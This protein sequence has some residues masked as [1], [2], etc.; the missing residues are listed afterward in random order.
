[1]LTSEKNNVYWIYRVCTST[2][3]MK[4]QYSYNG[5]FFFLKLKLINVKCTPS[6]RPNQYIY[7][8][9]LKD[10]TELSKRSNPLT[11]ITDTFRSSMKPQV[12][13][14]LISW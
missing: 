4:G 14:V 1:M 3:F 6:R 11:F 10:T 2:D 8:C 9:Y 13:V 12:A 5:C 7:M